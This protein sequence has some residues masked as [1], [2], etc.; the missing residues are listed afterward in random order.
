MRVGDGAGVSKMT[1]V[2][3]HSLFRF[4]SKAKIFVRYVIMTFF[5]SLFLNG[6]HLG[7]LS[8]PICWL[9]QRPT[10]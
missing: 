7:T 3:F 5:A 10:R 9:P 6:L 1:L 4:E 2:F 8:V